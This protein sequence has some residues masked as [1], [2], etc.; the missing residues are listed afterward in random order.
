M[1]KYQ[2]LNN[3]ENIFIYIFAFI[4][5]IVS[6]GQYFLGLPKNS[7]LLATL[8]IPIT[9]KLTRF[10][11]TGKIKIIK[12][13]F[14]IPVL[15]ISISY[16][17]STIFNNY[18]Q[19]NGIINQGLTTLIVL[20]SLFY[21]L[22]SQLSME[23]KTILTHFTLAGICVYSILVLL[24]T[25]NVINWFSPDG[26]YFST[27]ILLTVSLP[28][29]IGTIFKQKDFPIQA[30][31]SATIFLILFCLT[32]STYE[33]FSKQKYPQY[34]TF[35][36]SVAIATETIKINPL[37]GVGPS[38]Y[39]TS[40]NKHRPFDFNSSSIWSI[41]YNQGNSFVL[42]LLTE[43]GIIGILSFFALVSIFASHS[44]TTYTQRRK[45]GWGII[46]SLDLL[47]GYLVLIS[48][49]LLPSFPPIIILLFLILSA[50]SD[51]KSYEFIIPT[52]L[53]TVMISIP[54]Y[55]LIIFIIYKS[56]NFTYAEFLY[57]NGLNYL[58][59]NKSVEAYN[60]I[61]KAININPNVDRYHRA[62]ALFNTSVA[63][64]LSKN[65]EL[66]EKEK[67]NI[68]FFIQEAINESKASVSCNNK[69]SDN[70]K[71]LGDTYKMIVPFA[72]GSEQ[73]AIDAY[74]QAIDLDPINPEL[75]IEL[76]EVYMLKKDYKKAI[77]V[78]K[79]A[80]LAK[81]DLAN[82]HYN[83]AIARKE[84]GDTNEAKSEFDITLKLID[85][86]SNEYS[87]VMNEI[88]SLESKN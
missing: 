28:I 68:S 81:P 62:L 87:K 36:Q 8:L 79:L 69:L 13:S 19:M 18:G 77:E 53:L 44:Y 15:L 4:F 34:P 78:F 76:G 83:L 21:Y 67:N 49:L 7:I 48:F 1:K 41:K 20:A 40:F 25:A 6:S 74:K 63:M 54:L 30:L 35:K 11:L 82:P 52:K 88:Q 51:S 27:I 33:I 22:A 3:I 75:R 38:N 84:N 56:Y 17:L 64:S 86:K 24:T 9:I 60:K 39:L 23:E 55:T 16:L 32:I 57:I 14:D 58:N 42:T 5:P 10:I 46:S 43:T 45:V 12:A 66:S 31:I 85:P 2:I 80:V 65:K 29:L 50:T 71:L 61:K 70:W 73:F 47:S 72:D 59:Q 26:G 37:F